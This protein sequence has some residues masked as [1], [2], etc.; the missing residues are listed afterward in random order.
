LVQHVI[1]LTGANKGL[2]AQWE[3]ETKVKSSVLELFTQ[4]QSGSLPLTDDS[5]SD[6]SIAP[7]SNISAPVDAIHTSIL[8]ILPEVG[9]EAM[10]EITLP[11]V[12]LSTHTDQSGIDESSPIC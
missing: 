10:T 12:S 1:A 7:A 2:A 6:I 3:N 11:K 4:C 5:D 8:N 9:D